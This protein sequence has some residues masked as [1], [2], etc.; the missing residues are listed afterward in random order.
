MHLLLQIRAYLSTVSEAINDASW[1]FVVTL[2][3]NSFQ[4]KLHT[5]LLGI[6]QREFFGLIKWILCNAW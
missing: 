3:F 2:G 1:E 5:S 4:F 6:R